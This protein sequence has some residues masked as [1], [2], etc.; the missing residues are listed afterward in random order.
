MDCQSSNLLN[1]KFIKNTEEL[2]A[3]SFLFLQA[4]SSYQTYVNQ[5]TQ[6]LDRKGF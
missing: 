5:P 1:Q 3:H 2:V 6:S 4:D